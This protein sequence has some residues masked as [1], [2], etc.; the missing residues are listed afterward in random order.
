M[1]F[2]SSLFAQVLSQT[3]EEHE[4]LGPCSNPCEHSTSPNSTTVCRTVS[5]RDLVRLSPPCSGR[6]SGLLTTSPTSCRKGFSS[7]RES[8][9]KRALRHELEQLVLSGGAS[10]DLSLFGAGYALASAT[11]SHPAPPRLS[12]QRRP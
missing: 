7:T 8:A 3:E 11:P 1:A 9:R 10:D 4:A 6:V 2:I 12:A 5:P